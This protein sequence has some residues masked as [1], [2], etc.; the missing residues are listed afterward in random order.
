M[1]TMNM[2]VQERLLMGRLIADLPDDAL[3]AVP[4][5]YRNNILWNLG[6]IVV[7]QQLL[8]YKLSA[9]EMY[10][11]DELVER[12]ARQRKKHRFKI[13]TI[14]VD[15]GDH[16][17]REVERFADDVRRITDLTADSLTDM[18]AAV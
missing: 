5:G 1:S 9:I 15:V 16:E 14:L 2:H 3:T 7:S 13:R 11:S 8:L 6:H 17:S 18:F 12:I 4:A 10:V